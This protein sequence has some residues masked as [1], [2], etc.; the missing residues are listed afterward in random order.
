MTH[1]PWLLDKYVPVTNVNKATPKWYHCFH[2]VYV[3]NTNTPVTNAIL[4]T[5]SMPL[6][7]CKDISWCLQSGSSPRNLYH[8]CARGGFNFD[9]KFQGGEIY[10]LGYGGCILKRSL[11]YS[12]VLAHVT[13]LPH[14]NLALINIIIDNIKLAIINS[15]A[16]SS[17]DPKHTCQEISTTIKKNWTLW[18]CFSLLGQHLTLLPIADSLLQPRI[19]L[20]CLLSPRWS[21]TNTLILSPPYLRASLCMHA[22]MAWDLHRSGDCLSVVWGCQ[23]N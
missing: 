15:F 20:F 18:S 22:C 2:A 3:Y 12:P 17:L 23:S 6:Q 8:V 14:L 9:P 1:H 21:T 10:K 19:R 16:L 4:G 5:I 13:S 7:Y 11:G